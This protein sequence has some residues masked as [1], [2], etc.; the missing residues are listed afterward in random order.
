MKYNINY[1][2]IQRC[3]NIRIVIM[4]F[5]YKKFAIIIITFSRLIGK[6]KLYCR[7]RF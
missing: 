2:F 7:V 6:R 4:A 5:V 1:I 3:V